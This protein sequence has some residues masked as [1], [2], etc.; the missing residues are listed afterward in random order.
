MN[1]I[2]HLAFLSR[3]FSLHLLRY[4]W[5]IMWSSYLQVILD[6][7]QFSRINCRFNFVFDTLKILIVLKFDHCST[8]FLFNNNSYDYQDSSNFYHSAIHFWQKHADHHTHLHQNLLK[9]KI[10]CQRHRGNHI[11][12][13]LVFTKSCLIWALSCLLLRYYAAWIHS[14]LSQF[15][16][17]LS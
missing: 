9:M 13:Q 11:K 7:H 16:W 8:Y 3:H 2:R 15:L 17:F 1:F 5:N 4:L 10:D 14:N 6:I 12:F